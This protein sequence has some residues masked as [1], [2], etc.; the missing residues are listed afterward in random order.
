MKVKTETT[1]RARSEAAREPSTSAD[2]ED[3]YKP[4][5]NTYLSTA[6]VTALKTGKLS[7]LKRTSDLYFDSINQP[8]NSQLDEFLVRTTFSSGSPLSLVENEDG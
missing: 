4:R 6:A 3:A 7:N 1:L 8:E 2:S 5:R